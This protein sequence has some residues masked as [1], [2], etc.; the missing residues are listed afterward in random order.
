MSVCSCKTADAPGLAVAESLWAL[1]AR[2]RPCHP[3]PRRVCDT[4]ACGSLQLLR[5]SS[6][7]ALCEFSRAHDNMCCYSAVFTWECFPRFGVG[8]FFH[9]LAPHL[10]VCTFQFFGSGTT[11]FNGVFKACPARHSATVIVAVLAKRRS[12]A[13][14]TRQPGQARTRTPRH[15]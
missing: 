6:N 2:A 10:P 3:F 11:A 15:G 1:V 5:S 12:C 4:L 14:V 13:P 8:A 9:V 7:D